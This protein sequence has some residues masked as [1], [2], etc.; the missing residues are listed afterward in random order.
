MTNPKHGA[1]RS[2][3]KP[4]PPKRLL[5]VGRVD[6]PIKICE[7]RGKDIKYA[8]L[9]HCW[10]AGPLLTT[11]TENLS[12]RKVCINWL[13][14]PALFQDAVIIT[15][16]LG[17]RF[18]WIDSL[19]I[20]QDSKQDWERESAKMSSI[21]EN[22]YVT[23][24][25]VTSGD[26]GSH[27]LTERCKTV[28][29]QYLNTKGKVS[30]LKVRKILDHHPD[31]SEGTPARPRGPLM[32]RAWALQEHVLCSRIL[33]YTSTEL[34]F[35]CRTAYRCECMPSPKKFATTPALI[36]NMLSSSKKNRTWATWHRVVAQYTKRRLT[37]PSDKLPAI[38]GIASKIQDA[39][40]STYL[41]GLWRDNLAEGLLWGSSPHL[42]PPHQANRLT[43]WRAPSFSWASV[44]TEIQYYEPDVAEGVEARSNIDVIDAQCTLAG[45]NSLGEIT[46]GFI[47]LRGPV[48]EGILVAPEPNEFA[49]QLLIKGA[50]TMNVS[51]DSLLV[52]D[53]V[54]SES[55][56]RSRTVR[57]ARPSETLKHFKSTVICLNIA[58]YSHEWIS[59]IVLGLSQ[60]VPSAYERLGMFSSGSE[61][62]QGAVEREIKLV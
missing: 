14:L 3:A 58:S 6:K 31:P 48:L 25:A 26:S 18:L 17:M 51:P 30:T 46:D 45:L 8:S 4:T 7:P 37:I 34:I 2:S 21:Y 23:I 16:Q 52:E 55:G 38:S 36:P 49:Y 27:C 22:S 29:L 60:R 62:F 28:N 12:S 39:T 35:E 15:R 10:G 11:S 40:K 42:E 32:S 50:S 43:D 47:T 1:C 5:D 24:A 20:I 13:S 41:A 56:I 57:R 44:D 33:Y 19:C 53:D 9:S 59:G 61:F 54:G